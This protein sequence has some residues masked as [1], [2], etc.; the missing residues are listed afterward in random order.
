M[1]TCWDAA[2][3]ETCWDMVARPCALLV[4]AGRCGPRAL[5]RGH[6]AG[7]DAP[8]GA[9]PCPWAVA[10]RSAR[11][12]RTHGVG[13]GGRGGDHDGT[14]H[15][16]AL[17][18]EHQ[19]RGQLGSRREKGSH[20]SAGQFRGTG[21][22]VAS[23]ARQW[24]GGG[25]GGSRGGLGAGVS[26]HYKNVIAHYGDVRLGDYLHVIAPTAVTPDTWDE[27]DARRGSMGFITADTRATWADTEPTNIDAE[28]EELVTWGTATSADLFCW[29]TRGEPDK[30]PLLV[31][32][33]GDDAWVQH[34]FG[35]AE[36]LMRVLNAQPGVEVMAETP[37]WVTG[38][39]RTS[40]PR[41]V[42]AHGES[43]SARALVRRAEC[44]NQR[45]AITVGGGARRPLRRRRGGE[46][47]ASGAAWAGGGERRSRL[48]RQ[49]VF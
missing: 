26:L 27:A 22:D 1:L 10:T 11:S 14:P 15:G 13:L 6:R 12:S 20:D 35:M 44:L 19:Q 41:S 49:G 46:F 37:L 4:G 36:F 38:A 3:C 47:R 8:A 25:L 30:W 9:R 40:T 48:A 21:G 31:F 16:A 33:H 23:T 43:E 24:P 18:H 29:L 2:L 7:D 45:A 34:D 32:C 28:P 42:A 17:Q 39:L 5:R